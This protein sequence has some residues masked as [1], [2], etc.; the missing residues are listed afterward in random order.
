MTTLGSIASGRSGA[1]SRAIPRPSPRS[2]LE[3][4]SSVTWVTLVHIV[5][6]TK[7]IIGIMFSFSIP[8]NKQRVRAKTSYEQTLT[9][10]IILFLSTKVQLA[11]V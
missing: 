5:T 3:R 9:L 7:L 11:D 1:V 4:S 10:R 2:L 8:I 6:Y